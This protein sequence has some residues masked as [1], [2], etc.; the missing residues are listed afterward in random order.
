MLGDQQSA[1]FGQTC[2]QGGQAKATYGTGAFLLL[3]TGNAIVP[4]DHGLLTTVAF[5]L[6]KANPVYA[7][8]GA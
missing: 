5:R 4:S 3:N 2:F 7:L 6:G 8:E 1:L